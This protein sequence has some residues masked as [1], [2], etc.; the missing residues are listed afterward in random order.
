VD[1]PPTLHESFGFGRCT[2]KVSTDQNVL[3]Q[4]LHFD[5]G[6]D[7][8]ESV[9]KLDDF[10]ERINVLVEKREVPT[11]DIYKGAETYD[12]RKKLLEKFFRT[13]TLQVCHYTTKK[14]QGTLF[15][16]LSFCRTTIVLFHPFALKPWLLLSY[17]WTMLNSQG[18]NVSR[19]VHHFAR[20]LL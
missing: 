11:A 6:A 5:S 20:N 3:L 8:V 7:R 15:S 16:R 4:I 19:V 12:Q 13:V 17:H 14:S 1:V 18:F 9:R 2:V 10:M